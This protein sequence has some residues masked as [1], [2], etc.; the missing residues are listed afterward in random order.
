M[1][2]RTRELAGTA[3]AGPLR[4][5]QKAVKPFIEASGRTDDPALVRVLADG[6]VFVD[7]T[8]PA[9]ASALVVSGVTRARS[10]EKPR[11]IP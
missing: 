5:L 6:N 2:T 9:V 7:V 3:G 11:C 10:A 1:T 8:W 4:R